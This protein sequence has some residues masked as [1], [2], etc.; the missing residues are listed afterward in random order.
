VTHRIN[1]RL[2]SSV[3]EQVPWGGEGTSNGRCQERVL[4]H[5]HALSGCSASM[6][7]VPV[8]AFQES[9]L[10]WTAMKA[11]FTMKA[12]VGAPPRDSAAQLT[13][14]RRVAVPRWSC[15]SARRAK[16]SARALRALGLGVMLLTQRDALTASLPSCLLAL[17]LRPAPQIARWV[18]SRCTRLAQPKQL[19]STATLRCVT[20]CNKQKVGY[21][22]APAGTSRPTQ[23]QEATTR[24]RKSMTWNGTE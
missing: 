4:S 12:T 6:Q 5:L 9:T 14:L 21:E 16:R 2:A 20:H 11:S 13:Q 15:R 1:A 8:Q 24:A 18:G 7:A 17:P 22:Q 3:G 10:G 19:C 23:A